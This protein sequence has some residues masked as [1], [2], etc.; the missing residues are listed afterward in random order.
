MKKLPFG[1][2]GHDQQS[3]V[4]L[5]LMGEKVL[6][7][8]SRP[9]SSLAEYTDIFYQSITMHYTS[10][11]APKLCQRTDLWLQIYQIYAI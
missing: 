3:L 4:V 9:R 7:N 11:R 8:F 6:E 2:L 5:M 1:K 10:F